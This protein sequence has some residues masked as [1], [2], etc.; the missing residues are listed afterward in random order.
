V[1]ER[2]VVSESASHERNIGSRSGRFDRTLER[3]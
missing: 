1:R 3:H 2:E